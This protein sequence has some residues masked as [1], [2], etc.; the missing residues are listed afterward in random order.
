MD[1]T[2][3]ARGGKI[4]T[5]NGYLCTEK[6]TETNRVRWSVRKTERAGAKE[7]SQKFTVQTMFITGLQASSANIHT[8]PF[9]R[10][11]SQI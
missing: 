1:V 3:T 11:N 10:T 4:M 5:F 8:E 2:E 9:I 7:R 6:A